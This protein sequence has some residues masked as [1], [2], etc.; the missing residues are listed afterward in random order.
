MQNMPPD[1]VYNGFMAEGYILKNADAQRAVLEDCHHH[2]YDE[3]LGERI[4]TGTTDARFFGLY[5][6]IPGLVY[7]PVGRDIHGFNEAVDLESV[8]KNT[9]T[10]ALFMAAWCGVVAI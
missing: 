4:G 10:I 7:G 8:R 1:I 2:V 3:K 9:Q 6:D 5:A